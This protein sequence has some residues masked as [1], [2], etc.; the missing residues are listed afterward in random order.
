MTRYTLRVAFLL[1]AGPAIADHRDQPINTAS[2]L[3]DW[4]KSESEASFIGR[5][6][7]P[8]NWSASF[9]DEGNVLVAKGQW[10]VDAAMVTVECRVARGARAE[11]ASMSI[12]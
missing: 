12:Q 7:Q 9:W 8:S 6:L 5:G 11:Y 10:R 4:C 2:E 1:L 3:R